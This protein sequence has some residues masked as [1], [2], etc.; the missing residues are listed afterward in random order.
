ME[1]GLRVFLDCVVMNP[2][3]RSLGV[4]TLL[5]DQADS[6]LLCWEAALFI[7]RKDFLESFFLDVADDDPSFKLWLA[8]YADMGE[9]LCGAV[10]L[11]EGLAG[12]EEVT[13]DDVNVGRVGEGAEALY[14]CL[15]TFPEVRD[16]LFPYP[17]LLWVERLLED[18]GYF[19]ELMLAAYLFA[20]DAAPSM[21][22]VE[23]EIAQ[24]CS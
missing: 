12:E 9:E 2:Q 16:W 6:A 18:R 11:F 23:D 14:N 22:D 13:R 1:R 5:I 21:G 19:V 3:L 15:T 8:V 24:L 4:D 10:S 7:S 20:G 17:D